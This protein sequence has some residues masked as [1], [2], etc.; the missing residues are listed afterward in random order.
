MTPDLE[1]SRSPGLRTGLADLLRGHRLA[2][3][4]TQAELAS[5]A[6]V[7]VR[8]VRDLERGRASRPQRTTVE[9]LAGALGLGGPDRSAFLAAARGPV[10]APRTA[11][12]GQPAADT[13]PPGGT[14]V[15]L[16][17]PVTA[18]R[19]GTGRG[20]A[21]RDADR[22]SRA[23]TGEPGRAGRCRQDRVGP[24]GGARRRRPASRRRGRRPHRCGLGQRRRA[25]RLGGGLRRGPAAGAGGPSRRSTR[26]AAH[27]R[28]GAGAG[29]GRRDRTPARRAAPILRVLVTGATRSACP[30]ERVRPVAPLDVPPADGD[31]LADYPAVALFTA[32]LARYAG[33]HPPRRAARAGR[34]GPAR[35]AGC[36]WPSS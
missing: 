24:R 15:A 12:S 13:D 28:G 25:C 8:T 31:G 16:P 10:P 7:G 33:S 20:G 6:G 2:A 29:P 21:G 32:R 23:P 19:P 30:G 11:P 18:G 3:G 36:R 1:G 34:A 4:L 27:G 17:P 14:T 35:S 22:R 9:L 26:A 5:R